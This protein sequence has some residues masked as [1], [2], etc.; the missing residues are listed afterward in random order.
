MNLWQR[1]MALPKKARL[2]IA[3]LTF[4]FALVGDH[5][6]SRVNEE[7]HARKELEELLNF[8]PAVIFNAAFDASGLIEIDHGANHTL[9]EW[10]ESQFE[11]MKALI[12]QA[13]FDDS[14]RRN[15]QALYE[16][17]LQEFRLGHCPS[18]DDEVEVE[19]EVVLEIL[20][21]DTKKEEKP[22]EE[23][24]EKEE[25]EKSEEENEEKNEENSDSDTSSSSESSSSSSSDAPL[26]SS[27]NTSP[28]SS[29]VSKAVV[30]ATFPETKTEV[31]IP[32][33]GEHSEVTDAPEV[34][35]DELFESLEE[36]Y[37]E[38]KKAYTA[39]LDAPVSHDTPV[40]KA[41]SS[42]SPPL[43][44]SLP[45]GHGWLYNNDIFTIPEEEE[46]E[47]MP[48][49][50]KSTFS[51]TFSTNTAPSATLQRCG[52]PE[53]SNLEVS[54]VQKLS[55]AGHSEVL[56]VS[57]SETLQA[58]FD[59][60]LS[61]NLGSKTVS[62][63]GSAPSSSKANPPATNLAYCLEDFP[64]FRHVLAHS[65]KKSFLPGDFFK[66]REL[67]YPKEAATFLPGECFRLWS[68]RTTRRGPRR[69]R[70][71]ARA[72]QVVKG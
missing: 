35:D 9:L 47:E 54:G 70:R 24:E 66:F 33:F 13:K 65:P 48:Q 51:W 52:E 56:E 59:Q 5:V 41:D 20:K 68:L 57:H 6:T 31:A 61:P 38:F 15:A 14:A 17:K 63:P 32:A 49:A 39:S 45:L 40:S 2:Y 23:N 21:Q 37:S 22:E 10:K 67:C 29:P 7:V 1:W 53:C 36:L 62:K 43:P 18:W 44:G 30:L 26:E 12:K 50:E 64:F 71:R 55:G 34:S 72:A 42:F 27:N 3:G 58:D 46:P 25:E 19:V 28:A 4:V 60:E 16:T 69:L 11:Q 8:F